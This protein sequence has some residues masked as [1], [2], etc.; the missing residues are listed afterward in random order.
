MSK[1]IIRLENVSRVYKSGEHEQK[2]LDDVSLSV[3]E[4]KVTH[5]IPV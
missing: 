4:G 3:G 2:A 5:K 1:E